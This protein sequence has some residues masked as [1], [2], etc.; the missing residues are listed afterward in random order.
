MG[1]LS[2]FGKNGLKITYDYFKSLPREVL[3]EREH[4]NF[5]KYIR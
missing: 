5:E 1:V 3:Y 4:K 2:Y